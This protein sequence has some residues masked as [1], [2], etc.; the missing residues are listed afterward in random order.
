[1]S[2][3]QAGLGGLD[4]D[5]RSDIYTLGIL[6]YELLV[7][8][9]PFD[10]KTLLA[11]GHDEMRRMIREV[12]PVKPSSRITTILGAERRDLAKARRID[13]TKLGRL[14]EPDLDWIVMK[15]IEK[16]RS[17]RY[18]T[19]NGFAREIEHFLAD[20][21]VAAG[22]PS[23]IYRMR[24]FARRNRR[25]LLS[26]AI[27]AAALLAGLAVAAG[28]WLDA[29]FEENERVARALDLIAQAE[30][31]LKWNAAADF[32]DD[33]I[34]AR[35]AN[36]SG[37]LG[38]RCQGLTTLTTRRGSAVINCGRQSTP[39]SAPASWLPASKRS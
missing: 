30:Q 25:G 19:A 33:G 18:E 8:K 27:S 38:S 2:P 5:T 20:E 12:E 15:A 39:K 13:E 26:G 10:S 11:A 32:D 14:V 28:I 7:G 4:I 23:V 29:T 6:L 24:K 17:R 9:P 36:W 35:L 31:H 16:D 1:M 37:G 3:E 22:P 21:P 34:F